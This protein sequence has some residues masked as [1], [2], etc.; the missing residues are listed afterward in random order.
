MTVKRD[1]NGQYLGLACDEC[2]TMAPDTTAIMAGHGLIN[3]GWYCSGGRHICPACP[4]PP[5][6]RLRPVPLARTVTP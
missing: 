4:H 2:G 5:V 3:M 1:E 6:N